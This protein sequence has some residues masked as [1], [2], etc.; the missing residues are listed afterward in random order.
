MNNINNIQNKTKSLPKIWIIE[1]EKGIIDA[2]NSL[3][4]EEFLGHIFLVEEYTKNPKEITEKII[5]INPNLICCDGLYGDWIKIYEPLSQ[6][7]KELADKFMIVS[8]VIDSKIENE[9]YK[10]YSIP[11]FKKENWSWKNYIQLL[12]YIPS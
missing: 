2:I 3:K 6:K 10:K 5:R 7:N 12:D 9:L 1:D 11:Y 4:G 8:S